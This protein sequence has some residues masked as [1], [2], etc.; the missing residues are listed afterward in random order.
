MLGDGA[1]DKIDEDLGESQLTLSQ[2]RHVVDEEQLV[3]DYSRLFW[4][5]LMTIEPQTAWHVGYELGQERKWP[6]GPD[7]VEEC[8]Q[9]N[10]IS[11]SL[12]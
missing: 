11:L 3:E 5:R 6:L 9:C 8:H 12:M 7:I 4:T 10:T 1:V 2:P